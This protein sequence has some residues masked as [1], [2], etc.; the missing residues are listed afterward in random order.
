MLT[1]S[2]LLADYDNNI[3]EDCKKYLGIAPY[4]ISTN[5]VAYDPYFCN[6]LSRR[7]GAQSVAYVIMVL[8]RSL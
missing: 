5:V 7:Y 2:N 8:K 6:S 4:N 3:I 1:E